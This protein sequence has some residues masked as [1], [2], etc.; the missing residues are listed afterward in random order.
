MKSSN[1]IDW[2]FVPFSALSSLELYE[3]LQLRSEV[4]VVEQA[5]PF[6]DMDGAD[7]KAMHL[8]GVKG[9]QLVAY[10][11]CFAAGEKFAEASIGRV[12]THM[13]AR[14]DGI[15]HVLM[16]QA[17]A[18]LLQHWGPQPIRIG[19][20]ARLE[21]FYNQ[22]GFVQNGRPYIEDGIPHIEMLRVA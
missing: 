7:Q 4:F 2:R 18:S 14:G 21:K 3:M 22:H 9:D 20:Q 15:G 13:S 12:V 16:K 5:C 1:D 10:A 19:A 8:M 6:Q 11:R 17:I